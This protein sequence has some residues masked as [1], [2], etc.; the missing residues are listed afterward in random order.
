M[1]IINAVSTEFTVMRKSIAPNL[2]AIAAEN[3][4]HDEVFGFFEIGK[5]HEKFSE[6]EFSES[7]SVA[8]ITSGKSIA[9]LRIGLENIFKKMLPSEKCLVK[10]GI[11]SGEYPFFHPGKSGRYETE[12]GVTLAVFGGLHPEVIENFDLLDSTLYVTMDASVFLV[13]YDAGK[14]PIFKEFSKFQT[15]GR[16][17]NFVLDEKIPTGEIAKSIA[18]LDSRIS[19]VYVRDIYRDENKVG[20]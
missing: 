5:I 16:E 1:R 7:L 15:I 18:D 9:D 19:G 8:A 20:E 4:K 10:Q 6:N 11:D 12:S 3:Q 14:E 17:L 2:F 13:L